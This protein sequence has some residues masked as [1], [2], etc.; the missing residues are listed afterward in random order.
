MRR[1]AII[2]ASVVIGVVGGVAGGIAY[3]SI[4]DSN[5]VIHGCY[6][7]KKGDLRVID[8]AS[9]SCGSKESPL[10]W[11]Q[12]GPPGFSVEVFAAS[13]EGVDIDQ[14]DGQ[15]IAELND[16]PAGKYLV[17]AKLVF[18]PAANTNTDLRAGANCNLTKFS[19]G[20]FE[21]IDSTSAT[22]EGTVV[23]NVRD[24]DSLALE[25]VTQLPEPSP[26]PALPPISLWCYRIGSHLA[27]TG[28]VHASG[29]KLIALRVG[30]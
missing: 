21:G 19:E 25:G 9:Q 3:A 20:D 1:R 7:K 18:S 2:C 13:G 14:P 6:Q 23:E 15:M 22:I 16:L 26:N 8:S 24:V 4:P 11:S 17:S 29:I 27:L 30:E 28:A 10:T 12:T 5:G